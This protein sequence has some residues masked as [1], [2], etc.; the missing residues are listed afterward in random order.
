MFV[1]MLVIRNAICNVTVNCNVIR[2]GL[3][4]IY[5]LRL[6][7]TSLEIVGAQI[8]RNSR[9]NAFILLSS[10]LLLSLPFLERAAED[11]IYPGIILTFFEYNLQT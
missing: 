11:A 10:V 2:N 6:E 4:G 8:V 9:L 7:A 1:G 3:K 5:N